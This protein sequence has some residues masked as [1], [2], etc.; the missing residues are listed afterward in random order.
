MVRAVFDE[1]ITLVSS[2]ASVRRCDV[3]VARRAGEGRRVGSDVVAKAVMHASA[4]RNVCMRAVLYGM[5]SRR[6]P[7]ILH[8]ARS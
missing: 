1:L 3:S 5:M 7:V 4:I 8:T 6:R 2:D